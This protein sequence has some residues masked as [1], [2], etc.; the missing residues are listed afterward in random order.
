MKF[1][2]G[3]V[4]NSSACSF[5]ITN[6]TDEDKSLFDF[7]K[8][9]NPSFYEKIKKHDWNYNDYG[10]NYYESK[11]EFFLRIFKIINKENNTPE[12]NENQIIYK[13]EHEY[14][15]GDGEGY[16]IAEIFEK[17]LGLKSGGYETKSFKWESHN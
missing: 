2:I 8:E 9:A 15:F 5:L 13:G 16:E 14:Q 4:S 11:K 10:D 1:R 7:L 17:A 3:F 12:D 6:K